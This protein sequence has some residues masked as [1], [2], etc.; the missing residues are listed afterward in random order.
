MDDACRGGFGSILLE[1]KFSADYRNKVKSWVCKALD[2]CRGRVDY[3]PNVIRH[4][5]HGFKKNRGYFERYGVLQKHGFSPSA[6]LVLNSFGVYEWG[7][8]VPPQLPRDVIAYF[9]SRHDDAEYEQA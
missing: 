7:P 5:F 3:C 4:G 6:H 9:K 2:V 1:S 8:D